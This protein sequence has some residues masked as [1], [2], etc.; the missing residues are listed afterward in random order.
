LEER[1]MF[2]EWSEWYRRQNEETRNL[3]RLILRNLPSKLRR[4][5]AEIMAMGSV[6]PLNSLL[7]SLVNL[8]AEEIVQS[9]KAE[10]FEEYD[11]PRGKEFARKV[12][13][14][15]VLGEN[16][17]RCCS[18]F[19]LRRR[20]GEFAFVFDCAGWGCCGEEHIKVYAFLFEFPRRRVFDLVDSGREL[21]EEYFRRY[22]TQIAQHY[23]VEDAKRIR[24][25]RTEEEL[26]DAV[27]KALMS[28]NSPC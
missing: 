5:A 9:L 27:A 24:N 15:T 6:T 22:Y 12:C 1:K 21:D 2:P 13:G 16:Y 10:G 14:A 17:G 3:A 11:D 19:S 28:I 7:R 23:A 4:Y 8:S 26:I 18:V 20:E 25:A